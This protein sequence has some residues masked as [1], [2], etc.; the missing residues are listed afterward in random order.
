MQRQKD[1]FSSLFEAAPVAYIV[2]DQQGIISD[3]NRKAVKLLSQA[4]SSMVGKPLA[5][6]IASAS[7]NEFYHFL[8]EVSDCYDDRTCQFEFTIRDNPFFYGIMYAVT[9]REPEG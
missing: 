8:K 9:Y 1:R 3:V 7:L 4:K 5:A 6:Y 2:V